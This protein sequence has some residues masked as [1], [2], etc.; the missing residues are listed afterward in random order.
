MTTGGHLGEPANAGLSQSFPP[1]R[2]TV[3]GFSDFEWNLACP[4]K[5]N[6]RLYSVG[7]SQLENDGV[8][9]KALPWFL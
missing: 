2:D 7:N 5:A 1:H 6:G 3:S 8:F 9:L 4:Q